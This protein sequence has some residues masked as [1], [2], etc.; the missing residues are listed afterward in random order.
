MAVINLTPDSFSDGGMHLGVS[1]AELRARAAD[2][3][4]QGASVLDVGGESTR[5]GAQPVSE[6]EECRRVLPV[7][8]ALL[9]LD[10]V[11]SLDTSK[12]GVAR[13]ALALGCHLINDVTGFTQPAMLEAV[14]DSRAAVAIMHMQGEPRTMQ[15]NPSYGDVVAEVRGF[16]AARVAACASVGIGPERICVDPG[17][18]FGKSLAHNLALLRDLQ[19]FK[20]LGAAVLVGVSRKSMLGRITGRGV[21]ER[22]AASVAAALLAAQRGADLLRVHDVAETV[23]AL[24]VLAAL[25]G[26]AQATR[27]GIRGQQ[28]QNT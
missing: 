28:E 22:V 4:A 6:D 23:D 21:D 15:D 27:A 19:M 18:G 11:I 1:P 24:K 17:I 7:L 12:P 20:N 13:R 16:L 14:A 26:A 10:A 25:E 9:S 5:P 3:V 2:M 8:E